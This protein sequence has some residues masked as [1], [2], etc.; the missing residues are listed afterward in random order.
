MASVFDIF[1]LELTVATLEDCFE[2]PPIAAVD[3]RLF[4]SSMLRF[5]S[6]VPDN[7]GRFRSFSFANVVF[8]V[9]DEPKPLLL[10]GGVDGG[11]I[12]KYLLM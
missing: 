11:E 10:T 3:R 8:V 6:A 9:V 7:G 4:N 2:L 5:S 1:A 12:L